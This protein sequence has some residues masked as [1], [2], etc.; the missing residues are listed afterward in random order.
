MLAVVNPMAIMMLFL[1]ALR[2]LDDFCLQ[3]KSGAARPVFQPTAFPDLDLDHSAGLMPKQLWTQNEA[4][5]LSEPPTS[6][7]ARTCGETAF[8]FFREL[9]WLLPQE[10]E[11]R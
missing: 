7:E 11:P 6:A 1:V 10:D 4:S 8:G 9:L 2:V 3:L 5:S